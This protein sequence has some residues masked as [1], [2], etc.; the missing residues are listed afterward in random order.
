MA[1]PE[2]TFA[3][4]PH[5]SACDPERP[6]QGHP[7]PFALSYSP[8]EALGPSVCTMISSH[9]LPACTNRTISPVVK[10][11]VENAR[12]VAKSMAKKT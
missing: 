8:S 11:F 10:R 12:E 3:E 5:K 2:R 4:G 1:V 6:S 9:R 7:F